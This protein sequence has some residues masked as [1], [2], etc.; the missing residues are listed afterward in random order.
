[1]SRL[2]KSWRSIVGASESILAKSGIPTDIE[3]LSQLPSISSLSALEGQPW[4]F[5]DNEQNTVK[6]TIN[7]CYRVN[8][9]ILAKS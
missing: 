8:S 1:P 6:V 7:R 2:I 5:I 9:A 3:Q 4:I